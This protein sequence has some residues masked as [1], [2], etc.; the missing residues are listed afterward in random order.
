MTG[1]HNSERGAVTTCKIAERS[2]KVNNELFKVSLLLLNNFSGNT[3]KE[4]ADLSTFTSPK[5]SV[6]KL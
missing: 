3:Q 6:N 2:K 5:W 4:E 1:I